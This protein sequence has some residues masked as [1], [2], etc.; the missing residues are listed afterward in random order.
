MFRFAKA[1]GAIPRAPLSRRN[2]RRVRGYSG[3]R[4]GSDKS[5]TGRSRWCLDRGASK[6]RLPKIKDMEINTA[7]LGAT[8]RLANAIQRRRAQGRAGRR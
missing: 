2:P 4:G 6:T 1:S 8:T 3:R 7:R 5:A